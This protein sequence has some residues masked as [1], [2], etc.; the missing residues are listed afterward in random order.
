M[1]SAGAAEVL[2]GVPLADNPDTSV[3]DKHVQVSA[4]LAAADLNAKVASSA[5]RCA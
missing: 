4:E 5:S 3:Y 2:V 1:T